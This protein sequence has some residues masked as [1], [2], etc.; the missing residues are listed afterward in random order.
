MID[1]IAQGD[2]ITCVI[3]KSSRDK[4]FEPFLA[5]VCLLLVEG[6]VDEG[7][8]CVGSDFELF[9]MC[10]QIGKVLFCIGSCRSS[11][12]FVVFDGPTGAIVV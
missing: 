11:Q 5:V 2:L 12:T 3:N 7:A 1:E 10:G 8:I 9:E 6:H 4:V